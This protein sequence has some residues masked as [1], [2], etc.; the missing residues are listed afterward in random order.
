MT[1]TEVAQQAFEQ[2]F[3]CSQSVFVA[4]APEFGLDRDNALRVAAAFGGGIGRSGATC[5][6]LTGAL[7]ALGMKYGM[8]QADP[9]KKEQMYTI[10]SQFMA[11]FR[12]R[13]GA[14]NCKEL[15]GCDLSTAEG[16]QQARERNTHHA[17]CVQLVADAC[18]QLDEI[19]R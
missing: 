14:L 15:I 2:G 19:L 17:V 10:A 7:M 13:H 12:R 4:Y 16:R 9:Q 6:V 1:R 8:V 5:G 3:N 11:E 18:A